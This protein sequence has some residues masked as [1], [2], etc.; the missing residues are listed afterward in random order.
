[1]NSDHLVLAATLALVGLGLFALC[2]S[3][4]GEKEIVYVSR[5]APATEYRNYDY[6]PPPVRAPDPEPEPY[7]V[8]TPPAPEPETESAIEEPTET[9]L[10]DTMND[11]YVVDDCPEVQV[12]QP[13]CDCTWD[14]DTPNQYAEWR[15]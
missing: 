13:E 6:T 15:D 8:Y 14:D 2:R 7:A 12:Q 5:P 10:A 3:S 4:H 11:G 1:M 9:T